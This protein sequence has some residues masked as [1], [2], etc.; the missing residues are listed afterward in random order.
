M[1]AEPIHRASCHCGRVI[2]EVRGPLPERVYDCNCSICAKKGYL[3]WFVSRDRTRLLT[4]EAELATYTFNTHRARHHFCR[5]CGVAPYYVA[6]S[7]PDEL[8]V[9]LRCVEGVD[10][11]SMKVV[12]FD[13][14]NWEASVEELRRQEE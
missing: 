6:R 10:L 2:L 9:N 3:H 4:P 1:N 8:D 5:T 14:R 11:A 13:G 12:P 7:H